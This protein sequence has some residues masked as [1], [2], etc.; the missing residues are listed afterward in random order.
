ME[1]EKEVEIDDE[2]DAICPMCDGAGCNLCN[3]TGIIRV[4]VI[5]KTTV[6][7][8]IEPEDIYDMR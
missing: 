1:I 2:L 8:D 7:V 4:H 3:K 5:D 6:T